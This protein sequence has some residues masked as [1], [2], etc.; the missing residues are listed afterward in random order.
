MR[1]LPLSTAAIM[2]A[3]AL[4][5]ALAQISP[6]GP[7][8]TPDAVPTT[9]RYRPTR[10]APSGVPGARAEPELAAPAERPIGEMPPTEALFDAINRGDASAA[11]EAVGRG[12]DISGR[13]VLGLT[14]LELA[15][16]LGRNDISFL[17]LSLRGGAG[18]TTTGAPPPPPSAA[19]QR[20][21]DRRAEQEAR[22]Q[23]QA[24][25]RAAE[26]VPVSAP[27]APRPANLFGGGGGAPV[28]RA[29]FL[30]FDS[31]R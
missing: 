5:P 3:S 10:P 30:G 26:R 28:P 24:A 25:A 8:K 22:R 20:R 13:N 27:A 7:L 2:L 12:A 19:E 6:I 14:P 31:A 15:I 9:P 11:R 21:A 1:S 4:A 17:L 29:G 23:Q 18:Y 16:D